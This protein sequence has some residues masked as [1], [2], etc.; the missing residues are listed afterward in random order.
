M[1]SFQDNSQSK[2]S[3]LHIVKNNFKHPVKTQ[4]LLLDGKSK[5]ILIWL[6][7]M[8]TVMWLEKLM[9]SS[10]YILYVCYHST[11]VYMLLRPIFSLFLLFILLQ[12]SPLFPS[13]P[14]PSS[15]QFPPPSD[16]HHTVVCAHGPCLCV[17]WLIPS[18]FFIRSPPPPPLWQ[19][20]VCSI[21]LCL[22]FYVISFLKRENCRD[23][24]CQFNWF[25]NKTG[26]Y[27]YYILQ[28]K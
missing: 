10:Q 14:P 28:R 9:F 16:H 21:Y 24:P 2:L 6:Q 18:P 5:F 23:I 25:I 8:K 20:S 7:G 12:L 4:E 15:P 1:P 11:H 17:L 22:C 27:E 19:L 26:P 3:E 13:L